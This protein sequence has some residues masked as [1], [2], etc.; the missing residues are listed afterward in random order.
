VWTWGW[1]HAG[2]LGHNDEQNRRSPALLAAEQLGGSTI[3]M[4]ATG[5]AHTVAVGEDGVPWLWG[6]GE[7]GQLGLGDTADRWVPYQ[8][9]AEAAFGGSR[10]H[11]AARGIKHTLFLTREGVL[12][13]CGDGTSSQRLNNELGKPVLTRVGPQ[14][15]SGACI[16]AVAAGDTHTAAPSEDGSFYT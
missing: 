16:T 5:D 1:G 8:L 12:W 9:G 7:Y 4:V 3:V 13:A 10:V 6:Y 14:D 2:S 15:V 11:M